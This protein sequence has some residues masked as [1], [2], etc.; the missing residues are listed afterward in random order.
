[1]IDPSTFQKVIAFKHQL[2]RH[3]ELAGEEFATC[4][5]IRES[6]AP[7]GMEVLPPF[8]K[9]DTVALLYGKGPGKNVTLRADIDALKV[10]EET[11]LA[12]S[13]TVPGMMHACGHDA[14]TAM[15]YGAALVLAERR[16][17]FDGSVRFVWQPGEENL[18]LGKALVDAGALENP[19]ADMV[20]AI[21]GAPGLAAGVFGIKPGPVMASCAHFKVTLYGKGAHSSAPHLAI[22]PIYCASSVVME[23]QSLVSRRVNPFESA[24]VSVCRFTGGAIANVIPESVE[25]EGTV[26]SLSDAT[27]LILEDGFHE[28]VE[29]VCRAHGVRCVIEYSPSYP[30]TINSRKGYEIAKSVV[31]GNSVELAQPS[32]GAEDFSW[33]LRRYEGF[34][35]RLGVGEDAPS[36]HNNKYVFP[37]EVMARG[38][39]Y[40]VNFALKALKS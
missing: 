39:E 29:N 33:Y 3:P 24:V 8:L 9:T 37:D 19:R 18:A 15:L 26:R 1:M 38:I 17:E 40:F 16:D 6:I 27:A 23:L 21:H 25:L 12:C 13:S 36:L 30:V 11:G 32:M 22:D 4:R 34:Y 28:I 2:H 7:L 35:I 20:T 5:L 14:H 10:V 31:A